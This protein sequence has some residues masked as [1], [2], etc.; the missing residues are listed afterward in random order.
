FF[1]GVLAPILEELYFRDLF[2]RALWKRENSFWFAAAVSSIFFMI[3][4]M[5][6]YPGALL[7]GLISAFLLVLSGSILPS[8]LFHSIS[9]LSFIF[10]PILFPKIFEALERFHFLRYFYR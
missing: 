3:A 5:S 2:F 8:I 6:V 7:L 1:A 9:N 4:H 10:I